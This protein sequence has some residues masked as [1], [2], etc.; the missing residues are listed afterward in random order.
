MTVIDKYIYQF[1]NAISD[2]YMY[3]LQ[4]PTVGEYIQNIFATIFNSLKNQKNKT[5]L[6]I[7][8]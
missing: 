4:R 1:K 2:R 3:I 5:E 6:L 8:L 7:T